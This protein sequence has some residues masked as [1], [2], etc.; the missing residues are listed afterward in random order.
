MGRSEFRY[1]TQQ[2][3]AVPAWQEEKL[4]NLNSGEKNLLQL[5]AI[6][7]QNMRHI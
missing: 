6:Q 3:T 4:G 2:I 7:A 1:N 5:K